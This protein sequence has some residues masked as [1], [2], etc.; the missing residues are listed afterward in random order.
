MIFDCDGVL[1]DWEVIANRF[2]ASLV[3]ELG[4]PT[5]TEESIA[6]YMGRSWTSVM[7]M[8]TEEL[9]APPPE[10]L[11]RRTSEAVEDAWRHELQP[12]PG[13]VA[14]LD[15]IALPLR[16][17]KTASPQRQ[18]QPDAQ[19]RRPSHRHLPAPPAQHQRPGLLRAETRRGKTN[20]GAIR[21][22]KRRLSDVL[23]RQLNAD[24]SE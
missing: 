4:I 10:D 17:E 11:L 9:G 20:K 6:R 24:R 16:W 18:G 7:S 3:T 13:I 2:L 1:V 23:Y 12:V 14:A 19:P 15:R 21:S 22:L 5:T 8:L